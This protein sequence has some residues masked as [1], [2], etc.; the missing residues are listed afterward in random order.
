[1]AE[2][3]L[4]EKQRLAIETEGKNI[5]VSAAAGS[6]KTKILVD[7]IIRKILN[8]KVNITEMIIVTFTVKSASDMKAKIKEA[9][10]KQLMVSNSKEESEFLLLQIRNLPKANIQTMHAFCTSVL[11]ENFYYFK[12]LS[13]KFGIITG[14]QQRVM[15]SDA[16]QEV[17]KIHLDNLD[18]ESDFKEFL[19]NFTSR[20]S[21]DN[22][23]GIIVGVDRY[24]K[25]HIDFLNVLEYENTV[26]ISFTAFKDILD[27]GEH[28]DLIK[29]YK[30]RELIYEELFDKEKRLTETI[31]K[32]IKE[33]ESLYT[34]KKAAKNKLDYNDLEHYMIKLLKE[35]PDVVNRLK[36]KYKYIFF[37][38]YQDSNDIQN[39]IVEQIAGDN[40]LFFVGDIKQS[41]YG[42]RGAKPQLFLD[43]LKSYKNDENATRIDLDSNFRT[44]KTL[45]DFNN[46]IFKAL[47]TKKSGDIDYSDNHQL[48][49][50][51]I[52]E[53][54]TG[55]SDRAKVEIDYLA[56]SIS[57]PAY[58]A[59]KINEC[60]KDGFDYKDIVI[61][62]RNRPANS[63]D[64]YYNELKMAGIPFYSDLTRFNFDTPEVNFYISLL[65][66][67]ENPKDEIALLT[68]A[69]SEL[70][71]FD[72]EEIAK[73]KL[74]NK[75]ESFYHAFIN[76]SGDKIVERKIK[77]LKDKLK[78]YSYMLLN[79]NLY[80]FAEMIFED[81]GL[82]DYLSARDT[83]ITRINNVE[84]IIRMMKDYDETNDNGLY[85]FLDY[86]DEITNENAENFEPLSELSE[87]DNVVRLMT[88]HSSKGLEFPVVILAEAHRK[89]SRTSID[90]VYAFDENYFLGLNVLKEDM[91]VKFPS[92]R[93]Q[94]IN[95]II[96]NAER[97]EEMR[98]LYVALTRAEER[99]YVV[100]NY[101]PEQLVKK[102]NKLEKDIKS[103]KVDVEELKKSDNL[104]ESMS[105]SNYIEWITY[106]LS[107]K[108]FFEE[109]KR[110]QEIADIEKYTYNIVK[111]LEPR[112]TECKEICEWEEF[113]ANHSEQYCDDE[114]LLKFNNRYN[115]IYSNIDDTKKNIKTTVTSI[116]QEDKKL[117]QDMIDCSYKDCKVDGGDVEFAK[118]SFMIGEI[119]FS[120]TEKGTIVHNFIQH[121][122][123]NLSTLEEVER[124]IQDVIEREILTEKEAETI[125]PEKVFCFLNNE[126]TKEILSQAT[127]IYREKAFLLQY[128]DQIINGQ[129]DMYVEKDDGI[130]IVDFKTNKK[131]D[132]SEYEKQL[133]YYKMAIEMAT[134]KNVVGAYLYWYQHDKYTKVL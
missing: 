91:Q 109:G 97:Q 11:R 123:F 60:I 128:Q 31:F 41:I 59:Q 48:V 89:F 83:G 19:D 55:D 101:L 3:K 39:F 10:E 53:D 37:D 115:F 27:I 90:S 102:L 93:K 125:E 107:N 118:P 100:G 24:L 114:L 14:S 78:S 6:G 65:K 133:E 45:I 52:T 117:E 69:R 112:E 21:L 122:D 56:K 12:N 57:Q 8:E 40:N 95:K 127:A 131:I 63:I 121:L 108:N 43:R 54:G 73:I 132:S 74:S 104:E 126:Q 5:I 92:I 17:M 124:N 130:I 44:Y 42:F 34:E 103:N 62:F 20:T 28:N 18:K 49:C 30:N 76:Y 7:R 61:L 23:K 9:L 35:N 120:P 81:C 26:D 66:L 98:L 16:L 2:I 94:L 116:L 82:L 71:S 36:A 111:E 87:M 25:N 85:G 110:S 46:C 13:P 77:N 99:I 72:D 51:K 96:N 64:D 84:T 29:E 119:D 106:I 79:L 67:I 80:E 58:I 134:G 38:E 4:T 129:I 105:L 75:K 47:M 86:L 113:L 1:M 50:G 15:E 68:V 22:V 33:F 88:I 32:L 70:F